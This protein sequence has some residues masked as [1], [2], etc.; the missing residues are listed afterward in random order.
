MPHSMLKV[1][2]VKWTGREASAE[3]PWDELERRLHKEEVMNVQA[4]LAV[5]D[6]SSG[7]KEIHLVV[8]GEQ[9]F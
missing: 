1:L 2:H 7:Q 6:E 9:A 4:A 8:I 3:S 5:T